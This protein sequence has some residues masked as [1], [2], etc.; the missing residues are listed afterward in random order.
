MNSL[1]VPEEIV[2]GEMDLYDKENKEFVIELS[3]HDLKWIS[4]MNGIKLVN[5]KTKQYRIFEYLKTDY[6][7]STMEDIAGWWFESKDGLKLLAIND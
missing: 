3:N 6:L 4:V 2:L 5:P 1:M 7:D